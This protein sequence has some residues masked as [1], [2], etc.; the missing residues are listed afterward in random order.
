MVILDGYG[1]EETFLFYVV[2]NYPRKGGHILAD[3]YVEKGKSVSVQVE[4]AFFVEISQIIVN[5]SSHPFTQ[6][7]K[8]LMLELFPNEEGVTAFEITQAISNQGQVIPINKTLRTA[9]LRRAPEI[10]VKEE[11]TDALNLLLT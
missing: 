11:A 9:V 2:D 1:F 3:Y 10:I 8:T 5:G 6:N 7:D 4:L